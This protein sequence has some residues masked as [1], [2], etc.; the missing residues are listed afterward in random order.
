[1]QNQTSCNALQ[2]QTEIAPL[3]SYA[4]TDQVLLAA[5]PQPEDWQRFAEAGYKTVL[6]IRSD[7]ERAAVQA[8]NARA[9][10][11]R[12]IHAPWPAYELE[13]EH[14]AEFARIVEDPETGKLVFHCRSAT[15]VGLIWML[16]RIVHQ[17]WTREQAEA[18]LRA[19]G[20]DDDAMETFD[21]CAGD[22]FERIG[23]QA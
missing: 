7:P 18:E 5:Q 17:G 23:T 9:A 6:N 19:A 13:P 15:R 11:L 14:L 2:H 21:F 8:A 3:R 10:G 20:Y 1:M 16:Y 12:Y 4:V 22:F